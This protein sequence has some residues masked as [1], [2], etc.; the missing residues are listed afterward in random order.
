MR[1]SLLVQVRHCSILQPDT[2]LVLQDGAFVDV[3]LA[4]LTPGAH[5]QIRP[6]ARV[7][8]D[9]EILSGQSHVDEAMLTG[10][11]MPVLKSPGAAVHGG[12]VNTGSSALIMQ[13]TAVGAD[14]A[15]AQI[16][17]M[18]RRAQSARLP[19]QDLVNRITA[20]FV[21]AVLVAAALTVLVWLITG[22]EPRLTYALV[23]G[24]SVLIIACPC[25]MGL[26]TPT[27]IMVGTGRAADLGILFRKGAA[28]QELSRVRTVAFD[29]TGTLTQGVPSVTGVHVAE[30]TEL[31]RSTALGTAAA[32]EAQSDHPLAT[33]IRAASG[34]DVPEAQGI[35]SAT[36]RG[37]TGTVDGMVC[38]IGSAGFMEMLGVDMT[39][40]PAPAPG[41]TPV[42]LAQ[43]GQAAA[44]FEITDTLR[45]DARAVIEAL[46]EMGL[47]TALIT[48]DRRSAAAPVAEAL[49]IDHL[50]AETLPADKA[51]AIRQ[52][53]ES[54]PVAFVG[55]GI[56]D[57]PA[58]A[59]AHVGIAIG[60]GT[61]VAIEAADVVLMPKSALA[62]PEALAISRATLRNIKQNLFWAFAYNAALIPVAAGVLYPVFGLQLSPALAAGAMALSSIFVLSNALRLRRAGTQVS[63]A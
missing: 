40:L 62:V 59:A 39:A 15:L 51:E 29:K 7:P 22:P 18:V 45:D 46:H 16:I 8:V 41:A 35:E 43:A 52:L 20:W 21:P 37:L 25:A 36:A 54:G 31:D 10:E 60:S 50:L 53:G 19:V 33:A 30:G 13:A 34:P 48:G 27:S 3:P 2:A 24:V 38:H 6:G 4:D 61:D 32:L 17:D 28:L 12:T 14:T 55:D 63:G 49:G 58:L 9:G 5:V 56:N 57:A 44:L 1:L 47:T 42:Y 26:A 11:P 23:A